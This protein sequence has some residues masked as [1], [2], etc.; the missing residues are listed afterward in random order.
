MA[1]D[2]RRPS[3]LLKAFIRPRC[4][5]VL[6]FVC[7]SRLAWTTIALNEAAFIIRQVN[8]R[9]PGVSLTPRPPPSIRRHASFC[10]ERLPNGTADVLRGCQSVGWQNICLVVREYEHRIKR[11]VVNKCSNISTFEDKTKTT[12]WILEPQKTAIQDTRL[13]FFFSKTL[14]QTKK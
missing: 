5:H 12:V 8:V 7:V 9:S 11:R 4:T 3:P 13:L 2:P 10:R 14:A 1:S 6:L